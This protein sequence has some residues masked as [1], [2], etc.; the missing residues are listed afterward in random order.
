VVESGFPSLL[1]GN[2]TP[3]FFLKP[4]TTIAGSSDAIPLTPR[5]T[6]LDYE[7]ELAVVMGK[8]VKNAT[9]VEAKQ[10]IWGY[11]VVND[12]SERRL[13]AVLT[14]RNTRA[15]D[16]FFDWLAGKWFDDSTPMGPYI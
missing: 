1:E 16:D 9:S 12:I 5:N 11:T 3:Q 15:N 10:A 13:N 6:A 4:S 14:P 2:M 8:F 7:A